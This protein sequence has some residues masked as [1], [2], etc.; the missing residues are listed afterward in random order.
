[1][2][3]CK[4]VVPVIKVL[5]LNTRPNSSEIKRIVDQLASK[6]YGNILNYPKK[7]C[8]SKHIY[9]H[10]HLIYGCNIFGGSM[11]GV[12]WQKD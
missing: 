12:N 9:E 10:S 4:E 5:V 8:R 3:L 11:K 1:M 7:L 2:I 6:Y